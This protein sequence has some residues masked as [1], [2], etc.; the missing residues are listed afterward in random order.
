MKH[1][2]WRKRLFTLWIASLALSLAS[3]ELA[4]AAPKFRVP[5]KIF[6]SHITESV[7]DVARYIK[8]RREIFEIDGKRL[9]SDTYLRQVSSS[10]DHSGGREAD[11]AA[12]GWTATSHEVYAVFPEN[13]QDY[14]GVFGKLPTSRELKEVELSD[15]LLRDSN[16][17]VRVAHNQNDDFGS[18]L[19]NSPADVVSIIGHNEDGL[20]RISDSISFRLDAMFEKCA[21]LRRTC[22]FFTCE[23]RAR[24]RAFKID[25]GLAAK[26]RMTYG[27]ASKA[28]VLVDKFI[29]LKTASGLNGREIVDEL[30]SVL[31]AALAGERMTAIVVRVAKPSGGIMSV[32]G[33]Y[34]L[35][36]REK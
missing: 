23:A 17:R 15:K 4:S 26:S 28:A 5:G 18:F 14:R 36:G 11:E 12:K 16:L 2:I 33:A 31:N 35:V 1:P 13:E 9:G 27:E 30:P 6:G 32:A 8:L 19:Q 10:V 21:A 7:D 22:L 25:T 20:L 3:W 34:V 29:A 24:F